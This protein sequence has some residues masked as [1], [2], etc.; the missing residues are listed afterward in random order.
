MGY[1]SSSQCTEPV[2]FPPLL[3]TL[4]GFR[5]FHRPTKDECYAGMHSVYV[6]LNYMLRQ[7]RDPSA[8]TN[9]NG[10]AS[11][12]NLKHVAGVYNSMSFEIVT[13]GGASQLSPRYFVGR[14][15]SYTTEVARVYPLFQKSPSGAAAAHIFTGYLL[16]VTPDADHY[17]PKTSEHMRALRL[18]VDNNSANHADAAPIEII[19]PTINTPVCHTTI[20]YLAAQATTMVDV[21]L[22]PRKRMTTRLRTLATLVGYLQTAKRYVETTTLYT[23][24]FSQI[25]IK[26]NAPSPA[27]R[28]LAHLHQAV[29]GCD[30]AAADTDRLQALQRYTAIAALES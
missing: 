14:V 19:T 20:D 5:R 30:P 12:A 17:S 2:R 23:L 28:T 11:L 27:F 21:I 24:D 16:L 18:A 26:G 8:A 4:Q 9:A 15:F 6:M 3:K 22:A 7:I 25:W 10:I 29:V 1:S 13:H